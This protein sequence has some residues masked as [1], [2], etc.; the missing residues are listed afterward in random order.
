MI[1]S[2]TLG[3]N[4]V[5]EKDMWRK[6]RHFIYESCDLLE[7]A[8]A[9][10]VVVAIVIATISLWGP[11]MEFIGTRFESTAFL[12]FIGYVFNILI[13]IEFLKMLSRPSSDT[14]LEVLTFMVARHMVVEHTTVLENLLSIVSIAALFAMK[15]YLNLPTNKESTDIFV[16]ENDWDKI[17]ERRRQYKEKRKSAKENID[18]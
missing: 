8:M 6:I 1:Q 9:L 15:K 3:L 5:E 10:I 17:K 11:F 7:L 16:T 18:E 13:G 2:R 4:Y 14:V 12:T